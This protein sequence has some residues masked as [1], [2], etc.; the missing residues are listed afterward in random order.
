MPRLS[1]NQALLWSPNA[2]RPAIR[3]TFPSWAWSSIAAEIVHAGENFCGALVR[4]FELHQ[5]E[6]RTVFLAIEAHEESSSPWWKYSTD[7]MALSWSLGCIERPLRLKRGKIEPQI[8]SRWPSYSDFFVEAFSGDDCSTASITV[9]G[10]P[11]SAL[12]DCSLEFN[13]LSNS[14]L[15]F[16]RAQ[17][18]SFNICFRLPDPCK[19]HNVCSNDFYTFCY[20]MDDRGSRVGVLRSGEHKARMPNRPLNS[21]RCTRRFSFIALSISS[22]YRY[23]YSTPDWCEC[24]GCKLDNRPGKFKKELGYDY[25]EPFVDVLM[26]EKRG[27]FFYRLNLGFIVLQ[28]WVKADRK[29]EDIVL[30]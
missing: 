9:H 27:D 30:A 11:R 13:G 5:R 24:K 3:S 4:W 25:H 16:G 21:D 1:F 15:L 22:E 6:D 28:A 23:L 8:E 26:V 2:T 19:L 12:V 7:M 29:F 10:A 14:R 18:A 20:I 17:K